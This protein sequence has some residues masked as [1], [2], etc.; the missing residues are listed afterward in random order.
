MSSVAIIDSGIDIKFNEFHRKNIT[1]YNINTYE[2]NI[3]SIK[4][5]NGHGTACASEVLRVNP[6]AN[7]HIIKLLNENSQSSVKKLIESIEYA[8]TIDDVK[9]ITLS[10]STYQDIYIDELRKSIE[11]AKKNNKIIIASS[12]NENKLSY[13]SYLNDVI[14]VQRCNLDIDNYI[15]N[16]TEEVECLCSS[17]FRMLPNINSKYKL[18]GGN[19]YCTAFFTG[20][21]SLLIENEEYSR[22]RTIETIIR[23]SNEINKKYSSISKR[24]NNIINQT[25]QKYD[26]HKLKELCKLIKKF[27]PQNKSIISERPIYLSVGI[28]STYEFIRFLEENLNI[29]INYT[30]VTDIDLYS[31]YNLYYFI[32]GG[33]GNDK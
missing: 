21:V 16:Q 1:G 3:E 31:I 20:I 14:G 12:D 4:D 27:N 7:L 6:N 18:F 5:Y 23:N 9:L 10:C 17:I 32:Y 29:N 19:S 13:P 33:I 28:E 15:F 25:K 24:A 8:S 2:S 22:D 30:S 11:H 26:L